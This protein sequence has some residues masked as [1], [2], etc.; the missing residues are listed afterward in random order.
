MHVT[1]FETCAMGLSTSA[2]S[3]LFG[4]FPDIQ[5]EWRELLLC[6][7]QLGIS[8]DW[9]RGVSYVVVDCPYEI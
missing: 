6:E 5:V 4:I 8:A 7:R 3:L 9:W 2:L 1:Y